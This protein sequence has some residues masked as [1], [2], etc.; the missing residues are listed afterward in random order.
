MAAMLRQARRAVN[1]AI[2][3][4]FLLTLPITILPF[5]HASLSGWMFAFWDYRLMNENTD[6]FLYEMKSISQDWGVGGDV[7]TFRQ[8]QDTHNDFG[9]L[10]INSNDFARKLGFTLPDQYMMNPD[11]MD[12]PIDKY[13]NIETLVRDTTNKK[14][15][16]K[17]K[18]QWVFLVHHG[19][20]IFDWDNAFRNAVRFAQGDPKLN[21]TGIYYAQCSGTASFLCGI[22]D[23]RPPA[24]IHFKVEDDPLTEDDVEDGLTYSTDLKHLRPVTVRIIEF[25]LKDVYTGLSVAIFPGHPEQV[26]AMMT[27]DHLYEQFE[28]YNY[29]GQKLLRF[30][31]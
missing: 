7:P 22:W 23:T 14:N 17:P 6:K 4:T 29:F 5:L 24:L 13:A 1:K 31:E 19:F 8:F 20:A 10:R 25:P 21:Q 18:E 27:G 28:P 30:S 26:L 2:Q 12:A 3:W 9:V 16:Q 11:S 15:S